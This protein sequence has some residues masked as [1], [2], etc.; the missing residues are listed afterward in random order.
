MVEGVKTFLERLRVLAM[1]DYLQV[2]IV[3]FLQTCLS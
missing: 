2:V 3:K 1:K